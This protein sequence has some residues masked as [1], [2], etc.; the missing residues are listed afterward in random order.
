MNIRLSENLICL[1][2]NRC[3]STIFS[4]KHYGD[5]DFTPRQDKKKCLNFRRY[6]KMEQFSHSQLQWLTTWEKKSG[7]HSKEKALIPSKYFVGNTD[8][9][10][11]SYKL[12]VLWIRLH[13][14]TGRLKMITHG[15]KRN[16]ES[17]KGDWKHRIFNAPIHGWEM[18]TKQPQWGC[19]SIS[20]TNTY[21]KPPHSTIKLI[22][23]SGT[24]SAGVPAG[25]RS[26]GFAPLVWL[27]Q[28]L[29]LGCS[30]SSLQ[31]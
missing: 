24:S 7:T 12:F 22:C 31:G 8:P 28:G 20:K 26:T 11:D 25:G 4:A 14:I 30:P 6:H 2:E 13:R 5:S 23:C 17:K 27:R 3:S 10:R 9:A 19:F 1:L 18:K 29:V 16:I 15:Q 21:W